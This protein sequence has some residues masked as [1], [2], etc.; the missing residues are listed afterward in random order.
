MLMHED[1]DFD[2]QATLPA[3][4]DTLTQDLELDTLFDAMA[5]GDEFLR[6]VARS[7]I[8]QSLASAKEIV[9]RQ[10]ALRDCE[11]HRP[12]IRI[13]RRLCPPAGAHPA[14][15]SSIFENRTIRYSSRPSS[16]ET[17]RIPSFAHHLGN[18]NEKRL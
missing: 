16:P 13:R 17:M 11:Q 15:T 3:Q 14:W 4:A 2:P 1:R 8:L 9:R 18:E 10:Q 12:A 6:D 7:A 5:D